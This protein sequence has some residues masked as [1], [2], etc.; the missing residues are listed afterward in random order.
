MSSEN[1]IISVNYSD[2][3][4][5]NFKNSTIFPVFEKTPPLSSGS[6][7]YVEIPIDIDEYD[8]KLLAAEQFFKGYDEGDTI[9]DRLSKR[10]NS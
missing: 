3:I 5:S 2:E 4:V 9:Y 6:S 8:W 1:T 7:Y 10:R